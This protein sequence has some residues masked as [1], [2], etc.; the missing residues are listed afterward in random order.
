[1]FMWHMTYSYVRHDS[2]ICL[3]DLFIRETWL[4]YMWNITHV[5][6]AHDSFISETWRILMWDMTHSY[7]WHVRHHAGALAGCMCCSVCIA[8]QCVA[9]CCSVLQDHMWHDWPWMSAV[10]LLQCVA[11]RY[12]VLRCVAVCCNVLQCAAQSHVTW[13][14]LNECS[15]G[16]RCVRLNHS[17]HTL[18]F[19]ARHVKKGAGACPESINTCECERHDPFMCVV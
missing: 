11:V 19:G 18:T 16:A 10:R 4:I 6:V 14:T 7:V 15:A 17:N 9:V 1:M 12:N 13:L 8:L 5:Y 3:P 2:F